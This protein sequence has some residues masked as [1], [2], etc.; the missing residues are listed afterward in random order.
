MIGIM[1]Q[2]L[3]NKIIS[4]RKLRKEKYIMGEFSIRRL[5]PGEKTATCD[6]HPCKN[7]G[8]INDGKYVENNG[9][10]ILWFCSFC[11]SQI[12]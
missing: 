11:K 12:K 4:N 1:N 2:K 5:A 10:K 6:N 7:T 3:Y 8:P 9:E